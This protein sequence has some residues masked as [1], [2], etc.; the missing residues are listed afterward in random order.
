[1]PRQIRL[2][3][4]L[5]LLLA[6]AILGFLPPT[7][8]AEDDLTPEPVAGDKSVRFD[9]P[10]VYVRAPRIAG[11]VQWANSEPPTTNPPGAELMILHPDGK[12]QVLAPVEPHQSIGDR[13]VSFDAKWVYY[14]KYHNVTANRE[15]SGG[16]GIF[17][18][19]DATGKVVQLTR[20]E[21]TPLARIWPIKSAR[22]ATASTSSRSLPAL[23]RAPSPLASKTSRE[24]KAV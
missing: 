12:E 10:I 22:W 9:Y 3:T 4:A 6:L 21:A 17:K 2:V 20:Q 13:C 18:V 1:M 7:A 19:E 5:P 8:T 14:L 23:K 24:T 15:H 16:S 11:K